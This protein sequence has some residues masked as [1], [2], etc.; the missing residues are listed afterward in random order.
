M[1]RGTEGGKII[2]ADVRWTDGRTEGWMGATHQGCKRELLI[3]LL[4]EY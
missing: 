4:K 2:G 3:L 1:I